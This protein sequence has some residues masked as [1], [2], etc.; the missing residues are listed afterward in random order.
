M[1]ERRRAAPGHW[2]IE[3]PL[4]K[5]AGQL[6]VWHWYEVNGESTVSGSLVK[7]RKLRDTLLG[8]FSGA[9]MVAIVAVDDGDGSGPE[10]LEG[11]LGSNLDSLRK[12]L[13]GEE[14]DCA[15]P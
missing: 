10:A 12:C 2:V 8:R 7:L 11:F 14:G 4:R 13:Y 5:R 9:A 3:T 1:G 15:V 6:I